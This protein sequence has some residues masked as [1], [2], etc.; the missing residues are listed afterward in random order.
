MGAMSRRIIIASVAAGVVAVAAAAGGY[1]YW[2]NKEQARLDLAA[3]SS[4]DHFASAWSQKDVQNITYAGQPASKVAAS[5][6]STTAGLGSAPAKVT[7]TSLT[8][9]GD[10]ANGKLSVAWTVAGDTTWT[11]PMAINLQH[12]NNGVWAVVATQGA[13]MWA[14]GLS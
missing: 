4:A 9:D 5:F 3:R 8:R 11:Y 13:A 2:N 7:V 1:V 12:N 6:K 14:P 10:K